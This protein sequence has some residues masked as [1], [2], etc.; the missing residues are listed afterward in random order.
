MRHPKPL[1]A[2]ALGCLAAALSTQAPAQDT[3]GLPGGVT[4]YGLIDAAVRHADNVT[5]AGGSMTT[6]GDG[7]IT[8]T[9]LGFR[10]REPLSRD[11]AVVFT[12]ESGFDPS[13]GNSLQ[14]TAT[15]DYGQVQANPRF[16]GR[17]LNVGLRGSAWGLT[18]GR[19]YT[20]A[21]TLA[22]R[23]QPLGNPNSLAHSLFSS[24]HIAR[25]DN[26]L[27]V[28]TKVVGIDLSATHT[29][30]EVSGSSAND[31]WAVGAGYSGGPV[32]LGAYFQQMKNLAGTETRKVL[33]LGGNYRFNAT[34]QL[35]AGV[36]RRT[37]E[38]SPQTNKAWTVGTNLQVAPNVTLSLAHYQD[39]QSG[40]AVLSGKR[41]VSWVH[42]DYQLSK[43]SS[44]YAVL[45]RNKVGDGYALPSFMGSKGTQT[46]LAAGLR[47]RF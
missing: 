43:R 38:V 33:G 31:A 34:V 29:F 19:Q 23:F 21:H 14:G 27:R 13:S 24:H 17:D 28:D 44:L 16:W 5:A 30:G 18:L 40:S 39:H 11:L 12:M 15:A 36:M 46:G 32:A 47:H 9:R 35:F 2:V 1:A 10:G 3:P 22:A 25:Q 8:G 4:M 20:L 7:I 45:D 42:A 37:A 6:M 41:Q 26:M